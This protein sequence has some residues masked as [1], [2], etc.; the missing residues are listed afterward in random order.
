MSGSFANRSGATW[1]SAVGISPLRWAW[2]ASSVSNESK[3]P[4]SV[5]L[6]LKA[7]QV[8]VPV[9]ATASARPASRNAPS[10]SPLPGLASNRASSPSFTVMVVAFHL[11]T[12]VCLDDRH[13]IA[14]RRRLAPHASVTFQISPVASPTSWADQGPGGVLGVISE[15]CS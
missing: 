2:R 13:R 14:S 5:S 8:T 7:Y 3:M 9:S 15:P 6:I 10:S 4:Y 1:P 11:G 12:V